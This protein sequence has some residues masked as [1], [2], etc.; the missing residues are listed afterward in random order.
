MTRADHRSGNAF[1]TDP[2]IRPI[3]HRTE[4][5]V[6][7]HLFS[8]MPSYYLSWH[9]QARLAPLP[10]T[11]GDKPAAQAARPSPVAPAARS[12]R[13]P[14]KTATKQT[15]GALLVRSFATPAR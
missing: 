4:D 13:A 1:N 8:R 6:R 2:D 15:P 12:P 7:A 3:W 9:L 14:A 11:D 10:F 5:R